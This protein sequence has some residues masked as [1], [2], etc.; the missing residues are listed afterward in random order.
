M[1][2]WIKNYWYTYV[3][4]S[5]NFGMAGE[6]EVTIPFDGN[7][8][9]EAWGAQGGSLEVIDDD[10]NIMN[11]CTAD[12]GY[13][14][15]MQATHYL[16]KG[17]KLYVNIGGKGGIKRI[18]YRKMYEY[19]YDGYNGEDFCQGEGGY[20][21]GG[22]CTI[23]FRKTDYDTGANI[24][25]LRNYWFS[26]GGGGATH[27][28][29]SS[30][31]LKELETTRE[32]V[33]LVAGGGGGAT[34]T[35]NKR[36][37]SPVELYA[38]RGGSGGGEVSELGSA[39]QTEGYAFGEGLSDSISGGFSGGGGWYGGNDGDGGSGR[40]SDGYT[41][42][43][44]GKVG[45][46]ASVHE[47][48]VAK[49]GYGWAKISFKAY[50]YHLDESGGKVYTTSAKLIENGSLS[51]ETFETEGDNGLFRPVDAA[52]LRQQIND[53]NF[54][55]PQICVWNIT[56]RLPVIKA[57]VIAVPFLQTTI[58]DPIYITDPDVLGVKKVI[59]DC[60][61]APKFA[62]STD[63]GV[64]WC[65]CNGKQWEVSADVANDM[66]ITALIG[67]EKA[68]WEEFLAEKESFIIRFTLFDENDIIKQITVDYV[69]V[70]DDE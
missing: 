44:D 51:R 67:I 2:T 6:T 42:S 48:Y 63:N 62:C 25:V 12:G 56:D 34:G 31:E 29:L 11:N 46:D 49:I 4:Y 54:I 18:N 35:C 1:T 19:I 8:T 38:G 21:G 57:D 20:N 5:C 15:Y 22:S 23:G 13:G 32:D 33:L 61:G 55:N 66:D 40:G 37:E 9:L 45:E 52:I 60:E 3:E 58:T 17:T 70:G 26:G 47:P 65:V 24:I 39:N 41:Y 50:K 69:N 59:I 7:Y 14:G 43:K 53:G 30:G 64:N 36:S 27:I 16:K 68:Q 10:G 28:A